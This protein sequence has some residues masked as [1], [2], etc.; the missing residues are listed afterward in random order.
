MNCYQFAANSA[1][2]FLP[3]CALT[4]GLLSPLPSMAELVS[5]RDLNVIQKPLANLKPPANDLKITAWVDQEDNTYEFGDQVTLFVKSN[6]DAYLTILDTGTSG[7]VH[8]IYPNSYQP[9]N[10]IS[11]G[12]IIQVPGK[13]AEFAY[14]VAGP[15]GTEHILVIASKSQDSLFS[16]DNYRQT[17]PFQQLNQRADFVAKDLKVTLKRD[18]QSNWS[19]YD[20]VIKIVPPADAGL[21]VLDNS[22]QVSSAGSMVSGTSDNSSSQNS[23]NSGSLLPP[24]INSFKLSVLSDQPVYQTGDRVTV[25]VSSD[26]DCKLTLINI[27]TSGRVTVLFPNRFQRSNL[28]R[29]GQVVRIPEN[30]AGVDYLVQGPPGIETL[31]ALCRTDEDEN[32]SGQFNFNRQ[33]FP[34]WGSLDKVGQELASILRQPGVAL[35][36]TSTTFIVSN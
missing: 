16:A 27:G 15:T 8:I 23:T 18:H 30:T 32:L 12:Q 25:S 4:I 5:A 14:E 19:K 2:K 6:Q 28:I 1:L 33:V 35:S 34:D 29:A 26:R 31:V 7:T 17:G 22:L 36:F 3:V 13:D 10:R 11:A 20:K 9:N 21:Q 24:E